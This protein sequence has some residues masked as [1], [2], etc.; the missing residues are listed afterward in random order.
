M[1]TATLVKLH[2]NAFKFANC[3]SEVRLD[4]HVTGARALID[5]ED[6]RVSGIPEKRLLSP[7]VRTGPALSGLGLGLDICRRVSRRTKVI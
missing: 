5:L 6:H 4:A 3:P 7:Y 1:L 2:Q